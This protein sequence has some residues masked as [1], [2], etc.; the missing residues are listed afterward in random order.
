MPVTDD[1][2][3]GGG[4]EV[5]TGGDTTVADPTEAGAAATN[6]FVAPIDQATQV[7]LGSALSNQLRITE[8]NILVNRGGYSILNDASALQQVVIPEDG[9]YDI[10]ASIKIELTTVSASFHTRLHRSCHRRIALFCRTAHV[11]NV[12]L[13]ERYPS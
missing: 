6:L 11:L 13:H 3:G 10:T 12:W 4:G 8:A 5:T 7:N 1:R 9:T 2:Q